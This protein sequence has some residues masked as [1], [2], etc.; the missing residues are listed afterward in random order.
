MNKI[1]HIPN[2]YVPHTG[3]IEDV[4]Y[5]IV[6]I[7]KACPDIEQ[8]VLCFSGSHDSVD[9]Y[10]EGI[11]V[12]R[13]GAPIKVA[14]QFLSLSYFFKLRKVIAE[15]NPDIIH[16][17]YP[18]P[19]VAL[20]LL[21][22]IKKDC[23]LIL[24]WHSDVVDQKTIYKFVKGVE[25]RIVRRA[26]KIVVTSPDYLSGSKPL[27]SVHD[28]VVVIPNIIRRERYELT[29]ELLKKISDV[30]EKYGN[31]KIV[32][33]IG[34]HV[35]YKGLRYLIESAPYIKSDCVIVIG[36]CGP[37]TE[38]LKSINTDSRVEFVG[39]IPDSELAA[40]YY[41]ADVFAFPSITKNEAFGVALAEALYCKTPAV[42]FTIAG[43]GV[44]WVN[45]AG[46]TGLEV[47]TNDPCQ[48]AAAV[49]KLLTDDNLR[50]LY[51]EQARKRVEDMFVVEK[52]TDDVKNLYI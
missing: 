43:S 46:Q 6:N 48:Y 51:A 39:R 4:C 7:N 14:S 9:E 26:D 19:L 16:F 24:H 12:Y 40:Y 33:F 13:I 42:T 37:Q 45:L 28:K 22:A 32:L 20:F 10:V 18:N 30:R 47:A 44:N 15:F 5:N 50:E 52:I 41:A 3:G 1:L 25:A 35:P 38:W 11:M 21:C 31:R 8:R 23:R 2:F 49:D 27:E 36:G 17:H 34:R 29:S